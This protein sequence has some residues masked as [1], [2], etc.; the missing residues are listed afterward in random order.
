MNGT[1]REQIIECILDQLRGCY[2]NENCAEYRALIKYRKE[3]R[4]SS[5][6]SWVNGEGDTAFALVTV[7]NDVMKATQKLIMEQNVDQLEVLF[8]MVKKFAVFRA[9]QQD[10]GDTFLWE[11]SREALADVAA[12]F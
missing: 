8:L 5:V 4:F 6:I 1:A 7:K 3:D 10:E 11:M 9:V 2:A 12:L